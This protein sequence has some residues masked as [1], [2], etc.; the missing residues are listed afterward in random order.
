[1]K[2]RIPRKKKKQLKKQ[3]S[4][5]QTLQFAAEFTMN[6]LK[7]R[8]DILLIQATPSH[9]IKAGGIMTDGTPVKDFPGMSKEEME[10][11]IAEAVIKSATHGADIVHKYYPQKQFRT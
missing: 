1:M 8:N 9:A 6:A 7:L 5:G 2:F 11:A 10:V 3:K 4:I